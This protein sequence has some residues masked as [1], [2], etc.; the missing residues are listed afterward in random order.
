MDIDQLRKT[1]EEKVMDKLTKNTPFDSD[2]HGFTHE[3]LSREME[4]IIAD[5]SID[6]MALTS[7]NDFD[8]LGLAS[9]LDNDDMK[10]IKEIEDRDLIVK[11]QKLLTN[12][13][14]QL[15]AF[16]YMA[17][18]LRLLKRKKVLDIFDL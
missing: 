13:R 7:L 3:E 6:W 10:G 2:K 12:S 5:K 17:A 14:Q 4:A 1:I 16:I 15:S 18:I 9:I 11:M 8:T